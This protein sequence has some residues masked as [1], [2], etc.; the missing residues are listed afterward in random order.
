MPRRTKETAKR[1]DDLRREL[2]EQEAQ[3]ARIRDRVDKN[4]YSGKRCGFILI[5]QIYL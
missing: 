4:E 2:E 3:M 1:L 5:Y